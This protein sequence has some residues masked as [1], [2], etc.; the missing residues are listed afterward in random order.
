MVGYYTPTGHFFESL[1]LLLWPSSI[2]L[3]A[4][5]GHEDSTSLVASVFAV[6]FVANGLLYAVIG[7]VFGAARKLM[8][9]A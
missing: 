7:V 3:M 6:S 1:S 9:R 8:D 2:F 4:T 5:D